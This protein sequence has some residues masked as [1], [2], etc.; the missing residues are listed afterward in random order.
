MRAEFYFAGVIIIIAGVIFF[1]I[2]AVMLTF[3]DPRVLIEQM[4]LIAIYGLIFKMVGVILIILG[5]STLVYGIFAKP[6]QKS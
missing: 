6:T 2:E 3:A 1:F 4:R 5:I